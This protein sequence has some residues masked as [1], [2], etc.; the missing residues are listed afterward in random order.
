M[1]IDNTMVDDEK[2][3]IQMHI[4]ES[5]SFDDCMH[6][7]IVNRDHTRTRALH[8]TFDTRDTFTIVDAATHNDV[9]VDEMTQ[10][11]L[12]NNHLFIIDTTID[13]EPHAQ[14]L[15]SM[16][17]TVT[18][19][20]DLCMHDRER[21][22][23]YVAA[24]YEF[25]IAMNDAIKTYDDATREFRANANASNYVH[26]EHAMIAMQN[27]RNE[28]DAYNELVRNRERADD[29]DRATRERE[30]MYKNATLDDCV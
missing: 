25:T 2:V 17:D 10:Y 3:V 7:A 11:A 9:D 30:T 21:R 15:R 19:F 6:V 29:H 12:L 24:Q 20:V 28:R 16:R 22:R 23:L 8:I 1:F 18:Q 5:Y 4:D 27:V 26:V 13:V 14:S